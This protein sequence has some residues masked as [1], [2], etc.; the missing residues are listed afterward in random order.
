MTKE[1]M[2]KNNMKKITKIVIGMLLLFLLL[3]TVYA[4]ENVRPIQTTYG[5][6]GQLNIGEG[7]IPEETGVNGNT[8]VLAFTDGKSNCYFISTDKDT[9]SDLIQSIQK[10]TKCRDGNVEWYHLEDKELTNGI[11]AMGTHLELKTTNSMNVGFLESPNTD[12]VIVLVAP[13]N[14]IV[15]CFNSIQWGQSEQ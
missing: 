2:V 3:G 11:G 12:E 14:T 6:T 13:P 4:A 8:Q 10:G 9:A 1:T 5:T 7:M 15:N